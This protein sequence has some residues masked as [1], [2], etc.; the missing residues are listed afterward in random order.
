MNEYLADE[1]PDVMVDKERDIHKKEI[2]K[3]QNKKRQDKLKEVGFYVDPDNHHV[4]EYENIKLPVKVNKMFGCANCEWINTFECPY[5][6]TTGKKHHKDICPKR[7]SHLKG[8]MPE[9][10]K[11]I[12]YPVW[13]SYY[14]HGLAQAQLN[15][16]YQLYRALSARYQAKTEQGME[17]PILFEK[18][19]L[20]RMNWER[21]LRT[22]LSYN[23]KLLER[24]TP[25]KIDHEH[26]LVMPTDVGELLDKAREKVVEAEVIEDEP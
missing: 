22:K 24:E 17:D 13:E 5:G 18:I 10:I 26:K 3:V 1:Y 9:H 8:F 16:D 14:N 23:E 19:R 6:Y 25:K 2:A 20:A 21:M 4:E 11:K 15:K 12:T 7:L